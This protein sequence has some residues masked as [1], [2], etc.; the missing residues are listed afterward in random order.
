MM[1]T[2]SMSFPRQECVAVLLQL[3]ENNSGLTNLTS[4]IQDYL[5]RAE[6][7]AE[8]LSKTVSHTVHCFTGH[9]FKK[10]ARMKSHPSMRG[11]K[12][13]PILQPLILREL[14]F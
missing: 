8:K 10:V 7:L 6:F 9:C 2:T 12:E 11:Q 13:Q 3:M 5:N 14:N 4:K 1:M